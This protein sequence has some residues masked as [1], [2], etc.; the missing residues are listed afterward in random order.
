MKNIYFVALALILANPVF[1][2]SIIRNPVLQT[3]EIIQ[4]NVNADS[5]LAS[6]KITAGRV[7]VN[8]EKIIISLYENNDCMPGSFC[9]AVMPQQFEFAAN[10]V[11][12]DYS[13]GSVYYKAINDQTP[14]DGNRIEIVVADHSHRVCR[15]LVPFVT[16]ITVEES[17]W[18]RF[19][20][21]FKYNH[22]FGANKLGPIYYR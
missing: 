20:H 11:A 3:A 14:V 8:G 17:G 15:D 1:A 5:Y 19:E 12:K 13:C 22:Y 18:N 16:E 4:F 7:T 21:P 6:Y 9:P 10:I 2:K